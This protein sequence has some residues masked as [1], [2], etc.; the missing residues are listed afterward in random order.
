M[1]LFEKT[2]LEKVAYPTSLTII[3]RELLAVIAYFKFFNSMKCGVG[4]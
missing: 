4:R 2:I 1:L 3:L